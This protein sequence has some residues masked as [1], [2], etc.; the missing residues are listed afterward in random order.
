[1]YLDSSAGSNLRNAF[2]G[3]PR[4]MKGRSLIASE[5]G[6]DDRGHKARRPLNSGLASTGLG[7]THLGRISS[8]PPRDAFAVEV[9]YPIPIDPRVL[10][11]QIMQRAVVPLHDRS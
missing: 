3:T 7:L 1:L 10:S 2:S 6:L 8:Y 5:G 9:R 4:R 11:F